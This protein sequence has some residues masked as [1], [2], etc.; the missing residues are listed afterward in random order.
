MTFV[1][2]VLFTNRAA[3]H[4]ELPAVK[5]PTGRTVVLYGSAAFDCT[6]LHNKCAYIKNAATP[7]GHK[8]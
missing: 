8:S 5:H 2:L 3:A 1:S 6:T 7:R 4:G